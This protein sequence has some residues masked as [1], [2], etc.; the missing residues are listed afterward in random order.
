[1]RRIP[2]VVFR[3]SSIRAFVPDAASTKVFV[4]VAIP[5]SLWRMLSATRSAVSIAAWAP[6]TVA[7]TSPG[8]TVSPSF[9]C[10]L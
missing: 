10:S 5:E 7:M 6:S 9:L 1:M 8:L 3:V 4:S 2:G